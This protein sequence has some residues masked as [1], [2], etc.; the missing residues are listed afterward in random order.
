MTIYTCRQCVCYKYVKDLRD[1][2]W[3]GKLTTSYHV[4]ASR[5][6][7]FLLGFKDDSINFVDAATA[8]DS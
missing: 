5:A 6:K 8:D 3:Q 1:Y 7:Y 2:S 4:N